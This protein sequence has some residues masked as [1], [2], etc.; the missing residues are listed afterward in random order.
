MK[1]AA[2][3]ASILV[4][5]ALLAFAGL[6]AP[7]KSGGPPHRVLPPESAREGAS[8]GHVP[9]GSERRLQQPGRL[10]RPRVRA[11]DWKAATGR[12]DVAARSRPR[13]PQGKLRSRICGFSRYPHGLRP[14]ALA[15]RVHLPQRRGRPADL[16]RRQEALLFL[17]QGPSL[18]GLRRD[19][20]QRGSAARQD[21]PGSGDQV[22]WS[23]GLSPAASGQVLD[24]RTRN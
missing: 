7:P 6:A 23:A 12:A 19:S 20:P 14:Y 16:Q 18:E 5:G 2:L 10:L 9:P 15:Q 4:A 8:L 11:A 3:T 17:H 21:L 1:R 13:E 24:L 22:Q